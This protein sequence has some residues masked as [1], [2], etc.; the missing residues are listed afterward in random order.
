MRCIVAE[1]LIAVI[2]IFKPSCIVSFYS[3]INFSE[4]FF[5]LLLLPYRKA[6]GGKNHVN[7]LA[8]SF[9]QEIENTEWFR[10]DRGIEF[11]ILAFNFIA[12]KRKRGFKAMASFWGWIF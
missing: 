4:T 6:G 9:G 11:S 12:K 7:Q 2:F 1:Y 10:Y 8:K 3:I 5:Y